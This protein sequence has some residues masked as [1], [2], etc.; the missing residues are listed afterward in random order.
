MGQSNSCQFNCIKQPAANDAAAPMQAKGAEAVRQENDEAGRV[1]A[2]IM[3][4]SSRS[5]RTAPVQ[6]FWVKKPSPMPELVETSAV[7]E[8][9]ILNR[10]ERRLIDSVE[11]TPA[12]KHAARRTVHFDVFN[13][14]VNNNGGMLNKPP[15]MFR[16]PELSQRQS[17]RN[18]LSQ[19]GTYLS[20][21]SV[22]GEQQTGAQP[23]P[24][25]QLFQSLQPDAH[26]SQ[27]HPARQ[28][29]A[30][31]HAHDHR[32]DDAFFFLEPSA[33]EAY[34]AYARSGLEAEKI[35]SATRSSPPNKSPALSERLVGPSRLGPL[36]H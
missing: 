36:P 17:S 7:H 31:V 14:D 25:R 20:H 29:P 1:L 12:A 24:Q 11:T 35:S 34:P 21:R 22:N 16:I 26:Q 6:P 23:D 15:S 9:S 4:T 32:I 30:P 33:T 8:E 10:Q 18:P 2:R 13:E 5:T 3:E 27:L 28:S 19:S